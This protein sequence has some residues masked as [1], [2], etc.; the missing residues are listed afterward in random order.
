[1]VV[2]GLTNSSVT[3]GAEAPRPPRGTTKEEKELP[4]ADNP[5]WLSVPS[6][7][8][9]LDVHFSVLQH[10]YNPLGQTGR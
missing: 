10:H 7:W 1:M 5:F 8:P 9:T 6:V 2:I 3:S 4:S